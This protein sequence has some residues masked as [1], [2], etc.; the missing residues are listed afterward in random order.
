LAMGG[1]TSAAPILAARRSGARTFL[2]ESNTI[3]GRANRWLSWGVH[4]AFVGFPSAAGRL[5][6]RRVSITGTPV[7]PQFHPADPS[8]CRAALG[9][10]ASRPVLL[11]MGGSQGASAINALVIKSLPLF[12][13]R[14]PELQWI[15]LAGA[16]DAEKLTQAYSALGLKAVVLPFLERM[17]LA[18]GA[19][20]AAISRSGASSLAELA[21]MRLPAVLIPYPS[22][23]G[24]HQFHNARAF[25]ASGAARLLEQKNATAETLMEMTGDLTEKTSVRER[26]QVALAHW[27]TPEAAQR[28]VEVITLTT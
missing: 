14:V 8:V 12:S 11:V 18:L 23:T 16:R 26:M 25:E 7:R 17:E 19:A 6:N 9:L 5:H 13:K 21:A 1:F 15:H 28:I 3:P 27:H 2:H 4:Q 20:T 10:D 24:N 22:A